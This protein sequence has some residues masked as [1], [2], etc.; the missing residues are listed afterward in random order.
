MNYPLLFSPGQI[1]P[2][3]LKNRIVM[4]AMEIDMGSY[5][6]SPSPE[7]IRYFQHRAAGGAGLITTGICRV[8][9]LHGVS[10]PRQLSLARE[11]NVGKMKELCDAVHREGAA[12]FCQLHHPG[13]Q[14]YRAMLFVWPVMSF[15]LRHLPGFERLFPGLVSFY[16]KL[17]SYLPFPSVRGAGDIPCRHLGE[18]SK[19][20]S[21]REI[22]RLRKNFGDAAERAKRSGFD[23]IEL[24]ASHGY[25]LQQFLSPRTNN[26]TDQYGGSRENRFRFISDIIREIRRRCG[27]D[28]P[29]SLRISVE[30]FYREEEGA[31][32]GICLDEGV[33]FCTMAEKAGFDALN[34]S[35]ASYETMN[36]W[37]E[38]ISYP[39]GWRAYLAEAVKKEVEIPVIAANLI[40]S[41]S[42]AEDQL[43][44]GIQDFVGFGRP[45]LADPYWPKKVLHGQ[46]GEIR[47]C[48]NCLYC[49]QSLNS[50]A[51]AA[52]PAR[53]ARNP[54]LGNEALWEK[55]G[56]Q[57]DGRYALV[58]GAGPAGLTAACLLAHRGYRV[59]CVERRKESGGQV[60]LAK[61]PPGRDRLGDSILEMERAA[62]K[63]GA[64]IVFGKE[65]DPGYIREEHPDLLII[66]S[67]GDPILPPIP[68]IKEQHVYSFQQVLQR[69]I[70][71]HGKQIVVAG[72][73]LTGLETAEL[74]SED[75][76]EIV[77]IE[78]AEQ[79]APGTYDQLKAD[80]LE[81]M[82]DRR[83]EYR[84]SCRLDGVFPGEVEL[85][86]LKEKR[87]FRLPCDAVVLALGSRSQR[88]LA[89]WADQEK[90][91]YQ[92]IGDARSVSNIAM[93][94]RQG[95]CVLEENRRYLKEGN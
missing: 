69:E 45:F 46:E 19:A 16:R 71:F 91:E 9:D 47:S 84:S 4:T 67:G 10:T 31:E 37:L 82:E 48:I 83:V 22:R 54:F 2:V 73:G 79:L 81:R 75:G 51:W 50:E 52:Q 55:K 74:L 11:A 61:A 44:R 17:L 70:R 41:A 42:Q 26:R 77:V 63:A 94:V 87:A 49:F 29:I 6:G 59:R 43:A 27:D 78:M 18:R 24:H 72:S 57:G 95:A 62:R 39:P 66:A 92:L 56:S 14:T 65:V 93:A 30:E 88:E 3:K 1:G 15:L 58:V 80:L 68:G 38:P 89:E 8:N 35:S 40:R 21:L 28:F 90:I 23:G 5:D 25:L 76:N 36:K 34:I 33:A 85:F 60:L 64:E 32:R 7:L 13:R 53:C 12:I 20:L 86:H